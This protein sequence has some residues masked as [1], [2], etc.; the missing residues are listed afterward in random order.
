MSGFQCWNLVENLMLK[1]R[2]DSDIEIWLKT[3]RWNN[4]VNLTTR[5]Q[6]NINQ[7]PTTFAGWEAR[8]VKTQLRCLRQQNLVDSIDQ[9]LCLCCT[10]FRDGLASREQRSGQQQKFLADFTHVYL[11]K[12]TWNTL[13]KSPIFT[14]WLTRYRS[15]YWM[16][17]WQE[18]E[19]TWSEI[20]NFPFV[21]ILG[22]HPR[23]AAPSW[24][25]WPTL[26][27]RKSTT[28]V[29]WPQITASGQCRERQGRIVQNGCH[30]HKFVVWHEQ[31]IFFVT[32]TRLTRS[33]RGRFITDFFMNRF[34]SIL[35]S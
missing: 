32:T 3:W 6:P 33:V 24:F 15:S 14:K 18:N 4:I 21:K 17:Y 11:A 16:S 28:T 31:I 1:Q 23:E 19:C 30:Q 35:G 26:T 7:I 13:R 12:I 20:H 22:Q 25:H 5:K 9:A 2:Q 29:M 27:C 8:S 10:C 34:H